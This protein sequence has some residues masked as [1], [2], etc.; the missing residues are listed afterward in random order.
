MLD[1]RC[2]I[3]VPSAKVSGPDPMGKCSKSSFHTSE[4]WANLLGPNSSG[5]VPAP[6][7]QGRGFGPQVLCFR[8][9]ARRPR[10]WGYLFGPRPSEH[11]CQ[12]SRSQDLGPISWPCNSAGIL[13]PSSW[14][15]MLSAKNLVGL[16]PVDPS[17]AG[18][19]SRT[20]GLISRYQG[21]VKR[22]WS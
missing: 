14:V 4:Y 5:R 11:A 9:E 3:Q 1:P 13:K 15:F 18:H 22:P 20:A 19:V 16:K 8:I 12:R 2:S 6:R 17:P 10:L 7:S 21:K